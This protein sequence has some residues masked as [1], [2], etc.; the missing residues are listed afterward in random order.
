MYEKCAWE[1]WHFCKLCHHWMSKRI[2]SN[3]GSSGCKKVS[4]FVYEAAGALPDNQP[5]D[6]PTRWWQ[7]WHQP[8]DGTQLQP[9]PCSAWQ[10][11][12]YR[13]RT[14]YTEQ[15]PAR[16]SPWRTRDE[17]HSKP[18]P[19]DQ[20]NTYWSDW[21]SGHGRQTSTVATLSRY[22]SRE[23]R[24]IKSRCR[25]MFM[26]ASNFAVIATEVRGWRKAHRTRQ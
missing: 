13:P 2:L 17:V 3:S 1:I 6:R 25:K 4:G 20:N 23:L 12:S 24:I 26:I 19:E 10:N 15:D 14:S 16:T 11:T 8:E 5:A 18:G 7:T 21:S 9:E 22:S